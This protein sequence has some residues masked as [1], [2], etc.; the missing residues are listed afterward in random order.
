MTAN[1]QKVGNEIRRAVLAAEKARQATA[2]GELVEATKPKKR[3]ERPQRPEPDS[4]R[5]GKKK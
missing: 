2:R 5:G 4:K 1:D 3:A